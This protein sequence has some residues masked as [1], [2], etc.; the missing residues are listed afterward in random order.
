M[1]APNV[2]AASNT[3]KYI[4]VTCTSSIDLQMVTRVVYLRMNRGQSVIEGL[5]A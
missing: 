2:K 1:N 3:G 4:F 5:T